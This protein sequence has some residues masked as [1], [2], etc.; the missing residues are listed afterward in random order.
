MSVL[1]Q[2]VLPLDV[3]GLPQPV[4][5]LGSDMSVHAFA[6]PGGV[7]PKAAC[8]APGGECLQEP[9]QA[10]YMSL[11]PVCVLLCC[12]WTCLSTKAFVLLLAVPVCNRYCAAP[13]HVYLQL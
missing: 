2:P 1:Q 3:S 11:A 4:L 9:A 5:P 6:V 12:S 7:C 10:L 8:A 13:G